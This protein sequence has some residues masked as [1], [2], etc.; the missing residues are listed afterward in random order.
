MALSIRSIVT[1]EI[2][3]AKNTFTLPLASSDCAKEEDMPS[4]MPKP[5]IKYVKI[6]PKNPPINAKT[7]IVTIVLWNLS[8]KPLS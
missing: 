5:Y 4:P 1:S 2:S 7:G 6:D 8:K 3:W